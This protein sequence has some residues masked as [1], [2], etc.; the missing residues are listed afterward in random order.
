MTV[1]MTLLIIFGFRNFW[2]RNTRDLIIE[3]EMLK[4]QIK[5]LKRQESARNSPTG[6]EY[7]GCCFG[8]YGAIGKMFFT[9]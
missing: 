8:W 4:R 7:I 1:C 5:I 2:F 6:I 9:L 3:N